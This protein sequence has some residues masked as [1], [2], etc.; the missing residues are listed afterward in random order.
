MLLAW[1]FVSQSG[2]LAGWT[3]RI[4]LLRRLCVLSSDAWDVKRDE[5][6]GGSC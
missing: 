2:L 4:G 3:F 1:R 5:L 6:E